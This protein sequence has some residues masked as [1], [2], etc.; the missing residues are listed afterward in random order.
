[1]TLKISNLK[2]PSNK[3]F[4]RIGDILLYTL[5]LYS[6]AIVASPCPDKLK[7]WLNFVLTVAVI[8]L[9]G[10]TKFSAEAE[11]LPEVEIPQESILR[12]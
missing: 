5:P 7:L 2:K 8:T 11:V 6:V 1:M 9:K 12:A 3:K 10:I 4:K